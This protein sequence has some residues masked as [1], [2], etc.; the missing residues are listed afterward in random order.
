MTPQFLSPASRDSSDVSAPLGVLKLLFSEQS[1]YLIIPS[2]SKKDE[3]LLRSLLVLDRH[4]VILVRE[5][6]VGHVR[7][8]IHV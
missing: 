1:G 6:V 3:P 4:P 7:G 5:F 2:V 8:I